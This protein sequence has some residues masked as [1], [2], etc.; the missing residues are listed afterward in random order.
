MKSGHVT[1]YLSGTTV[2]NI[3][4]YNE[5]ETKLNK[6]EQLTPE[7]TDEFQTLEQ[8][9]FYATFHKMWGQAIHNGLMEEPNNG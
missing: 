9:I 6:G 2:K 1:I 8:A 7:E 5:L 3:H 4:R